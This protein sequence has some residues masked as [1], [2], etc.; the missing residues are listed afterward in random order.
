MTDIS[1][2]RV[3][4]RFAK[5]E[6]DRQMVR[7]AGAG[8]ASYADCGPPNWNRASWEAFKAQYGSYPYS[9]SMLP[10]NFEG[11]PAWAYEA[12]GLRQPPIT[13]RPT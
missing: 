4:Q 13:V 8:T 5:Q 12:M 2:L 1:T 11:C 6:Y 7:D 3:A 10:A 9:A